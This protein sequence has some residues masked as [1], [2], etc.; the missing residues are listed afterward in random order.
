MSHDWPSPAQLAKIGLPVM[1]TQ[2]AEGGMASV[3]ADN[4]RREQAGS[5]VA[6]SDE[7][8]VVVDCGQ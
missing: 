5:S 2:A 6:D 3:G 7:P 4:H 8:P 1:L